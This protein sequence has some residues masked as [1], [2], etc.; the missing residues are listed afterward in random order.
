[1]AL[2]DALDRFPVRR[3]GRRRRDCERGEGIAVVPVI[4]L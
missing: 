4:V 2:S 3:S 1:M